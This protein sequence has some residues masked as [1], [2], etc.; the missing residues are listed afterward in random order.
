MSNKK[1]IDLILSEGSKKA[2][3]TAKQVLKKSQNKTRFLIY[4]LSKKNVHL[5][6]AISQCD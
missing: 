5:L 4:L 2:E 6:N 3:I 1:E